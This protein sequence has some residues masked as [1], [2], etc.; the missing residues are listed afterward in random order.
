[1]KTHDFNYVN[2]NISTLYTLSTTGFN[3]VNPV[4]GSTKV[5][6]VTEI[7][8]K[9]YITDKDNIQSIQDREEAQNSPSPLS[10]EDIWIDCKSILKT[11]ISQVTF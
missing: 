10:I 3:S 7:T 9:S 6:P 2:K 1:M 5:N 4:T 11:I 8:N